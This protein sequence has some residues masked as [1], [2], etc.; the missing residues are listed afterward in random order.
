MHCRAIP[1]ECAKKIVKKN[2]EEKGEN[3]SGQGTVSRGRPDFSR[4]QE[5]LTRVTAGW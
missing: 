2:K 5:G 1:E 4:A 3:I